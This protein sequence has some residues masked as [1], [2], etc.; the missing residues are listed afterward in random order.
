MAKRKWLKIGAGLGVGIVTILGFFQLLA[1]LY[2]FQITDLTGD[3]YC[4][5][6]FENPCISYFD[7]RNP[8]AYYVDIYNKNQTKLDFSPEI[9]DHALFVKDGRCSATGACRCELKDGKLIGFDG[10]R[11]VDFTNKTKPRQDKVYVFRFPAYTTKHFMLAGIKKNPSDTIKWGFGVADEF[12]DPVW[13]GEDRDIGYEFLD[14]NSVV[15]IWNTQDDYYF[16]RTSGIQFTN[17][18]QEYWTKNIFCIGYYD[19]EEWV[20]IKCADELENFNRDIHTDNSTYVNATLWK[21][22]TYSGY[23][24]R[25]GVRYHLG[26]DDEKLSITIYGKNLG[27]D[28]PVDLGF[29]WKVK[30][31]DVPIETTDKILINNT[32]YELDGT[33]DL[34]FKDMKR[35]VNTSFPTNQTTGNG[36]MIYNYSMV[37]VPIPYYK[38]YDYEGGLAGKENFLRIDWNKNLNYALKMVGNGNQSDFYVALLINAGHFNSQQEKSTTFYW[39][40]ALNDNLISYYKLDEQA[41]ATGTIYDSVEAN[42]GTNDGADSTGGKINTA[43]N[44]VGGNT[45]KIII[46]AGTGTIADITDGPLTINAWMRADSLGHQKGIVSGST[47]AWGFYT[48]ISGVLSFGKIG[49]DEKKGDDLFLLNEWAMVTVTYDGSA[50]SVQFY[51]N[52]TADSGGPFAYSTTFTVNLEKNIGAMINN[53]WFDGEID[54]VGIWT[55]ILSQEEVTELWNDGAGLTYPFSDEIPPTYSNNQTNTTVVGAFTLFSILYDDETELEPDGDWVFSTNNTGVWVNDSAVSFTATPE[56]ANVTKTLNTTYGTVIGYRW[57]ANDSAGNWNN[58]EIYVLTVSDQTAPSVILNSPVDNYNSAS[59]SITFNGT[60]SDS[61]LV[62]VSLYGN[63]SGWHLN[64]TNSSGI[65]DVD[66]IFN[67]DISDGIYIWNYY[68]CDVPNNCSFATANRTFTIDTI[69]PTINVDSPTNSSY[70]TPTI[71]FN[72]TADEVIDTWIVNYNG[73]NVTHTINTSLSVED[74]NHHLFLYGNDTFG[75]FG[76]NDSVYFT[77]DTTD[78]SISYDATTTGA[79]YQPQNFIFVNITCSDIHKDTIIFNWNGTNETFDNSE[80]DSYW[81]NQTSLADGNYTFYAYCNDTFGNSNQTSTRKVKLDTIIPAVYYNPNTDSYFVDRDWILVNITATDT[82]LDSVRLEWNGTNET[83]DNSDGD[84]YYENKTSLSDGNYTFYGWANDSSGRYNFTATR[85]INIDTVNP[86]IEFTTGTKDNDSLFDGDWI[87]ANVS[88]TEVNF[89]NI[90][91]RLYNSTS[92]VNSTTY[93]TR[94]Y[95]INWT[96]LPGEFYYYNVTVRDGGSRSNT[97]ETRKITLAH[98]TLFFNGVE[99][100]ITAELGGIINITAKATANIS[101]CLDIDYVGYGTNYSCGY[102]ANTL[103]FT[104]TY[105]RKTTFS[106]GSTNQTYNYS[107][108]Q[109]EFFDISIRAHI[110]DEVDNLAV[111]ISLGSGS[112]EDVTFYFVNTTPTFSGTVLDSNSSQFIDRTFHGLITGNNL[113][114][115]KFFGCNS[116]DNITFQVASE[117][118]VYFMLD[119][120]IVNKVYTF[121]FNITGFLFGFSYADGTVTA[122]TGFDNYSNIDTSL[123]TAHLDASG[124]IMARNVSEALYIYDN[125]G[126][127][128]LNQTLWVNSS[129]QKA[130]DDVACVSETGGVMKLEVDLFDASGGVAIQSLLLDKAESGIINFSIDADYGANNPPGSTITP[131]TFI[132][133]GGTTLWNMTVLNVVGVALGETVDAELDFYLYKVNRTHWAYRIYGTE[134]VTASGNPN[135]PINIVYS[136]TE[137]F[138]NVS[139]SQLFFYDYLLAG[140]DGGTNILE[141]AYVNRTLWTREK[142]SVISKSIYDASGDITQAQMWVGVINI[143]TTPN[144]SL[145]AF[146]SADDGENWESVYDNGTLHAFSYPGRHLRWRFDFNITGA[147]DYNSTIQIYKVNVSIPSGY[148]ENITFDFGGDGSIE[149]N[150]SGQLNSSKTINLSYTNLSLAFNSGTQYWNHTYR[151]PLVISSNTTGLI[152]IDAINLTYNPNPISLN[153]SKIQSY[154]GLG[155][156]F[157][158]FT[159]PISYNNNTEIDASVIIDDLRYDYAGGNKTVIISAYD[160]TNIL[161]A[162]KQIIYYYS[163][164]DYFFVPRFINWLEFIPS[165][166]T[167]KNITPSGQTPVIPILNITNY[168][169]GGKNTNL[170]IYLNETLS[171]VNLTMSLTNKSDGFIINDSW[172]NLTGLT[173]LQTVNISMWA[174]FGCNYA[175][176]YLFDPYLYFRQCCFGCYCGEELE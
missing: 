75:N 49:T 132:K 104:P 103:N 110:Y 162:T 149:Y 1:V 129:C 6:T 33:Y 161:N 59:N 116:T 164:W 36:T 123:T 83:F 95:Q 16:N 135:S 115:N 93:T 146:L 11:C 10:W 47:A 32:N 156:G 155:G 99:G 66:Y 113:Y 67:K 48:H 78:P 28:I 23:D 122:P 50:N 89:K 109:Q 31:I 108:E 120:D 138:V 14:N 114:L 2:G 52:G 143:D 85:E 91:F 5:G 69:P 90:T 136:G 71:Y 68:A 112:P 106:N 165:T 86:L 60:V 128:I 55:K 22:F 63:W 19:G 9:E 40:D 175:N 124:H 25:L 153:A 148:P 127:G 139:H 92:E 27:E 118:T 76:L 20:K 97:T 18:F 65:T 163:R 137:K 131:E 64:E 105:F 46:D 53:Y 154:L 119:D 17:H 176:W 166:P 88:V 72:A 73:T 125:F 96:N 126:D 37:G 35:Y 150:Y 141:V 70:A 41:G 174:D 8:N 29:A 171:C 39:I 62:D 61:T 102:G 58:T 133:F 94:I 54:E 167:S 157:I 30:S 44:F 168:G 107:S 77:V 142:S 158:N 21:D 159:I 170:S 111:N 87:F 45:D 147:D 26:L 74:G 130:G 145:F 81:E 51:L 117:K 80:G 13:F 4:E 121:F 12:L 98:L 79:G 57:Y 160:I 172:Q 152:Q 3:I 173:Y 56:W 101:I 151:I 100:N 42:D 38:I 144:E 7:V 24:L 34:L 15:H 140:G 134:N 82:N 84:F 169:Y 43:Y